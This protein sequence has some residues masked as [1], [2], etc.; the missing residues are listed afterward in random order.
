MRALL[1]KQMVSRL[2][3]VMWAVPYVAQGE[4]NNEDTQRKVY[5]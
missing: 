4:G 1:G 3:N 5:F 2:V